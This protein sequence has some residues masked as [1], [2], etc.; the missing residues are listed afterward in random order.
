MLS[1]QENVKVKA[2]VLLARTINQHSQFTC[3]FVISG[4]MW[5]FRVKAEAREFY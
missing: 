2:E 4:F 3:S 5:M 1:L